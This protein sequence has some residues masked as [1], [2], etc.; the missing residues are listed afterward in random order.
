MALFRCLR[1]APLAAQSHRCA[2]QSLRAPILASRA[3]PVLNQSPFSGSLPARR[4]NSGLSSALEAEVAEFQT[5]EEENVRL[6]LNNLRQQLSPAME[7]TEDAAVTEIRYAP[8]AGVGSQTEVITV[9]F[10]CQD[11]S[12]MP[13]GKS[14]DA[15]VGAPVTFNILV[16]F[17]G[18]GRS[19]SFDCEGFNETITIN[20]VHVYDDNQDPEMAYHGPV[21]SELADDLQDGFYNYLDERLVGPEFGTWI[22]K[23][24]YYKEMECYGEWLDKL[25]SVL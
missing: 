21:F 13:D 25:R 19:I 11:N 9:K 2:T 16:E 17:E 6:A 1:S 10:H 7:L 12:E 24:A 4:W 15:A 14:V 8:P 23:F 22:T 18:I 3:A 5:D 20:Q